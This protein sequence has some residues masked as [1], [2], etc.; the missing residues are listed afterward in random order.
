[1]TD[2]LIQLPIAE[3]DRLAREQVEH[4]RA[5]MSRWRQSRAKRV[6]QERDAGRSV[7]DI[8]TE[9]GVTQQV[10]YDL[11]REARKVVD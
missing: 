8:A 6:A 9:M 7:A 10:V 2:E 3:A 1:V 4:H 5:E 11:L